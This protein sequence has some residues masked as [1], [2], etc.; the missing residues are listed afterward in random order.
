MNNQ[1]ETSSDHHAEARDVSTEED[2]S[3]G[4]SRNPIT[5]EVRE[6]HA[7]GGPNQHDLSAEEPDIDT[8][9]QYH[10]ATEGRPTPEE[11]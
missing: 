2:R 3:A 4:T 10:G 7:L 6:R 8:A 9:R 1:P 5:G 11:A